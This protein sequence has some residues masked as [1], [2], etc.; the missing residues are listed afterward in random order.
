MGE[1]TKKLMEIISDPEKLARLERELEAARA[2]QSEECRCGRAKRR[3]HAFCHPC[4]SRLPREFHSGLR[5][6]V[7]EGFEDTYREALA[8]LKED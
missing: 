8:W 5:L 3:K 6:N 4:W 2:L 7:G 1:R